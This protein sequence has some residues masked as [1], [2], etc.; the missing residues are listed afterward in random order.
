[1][2][3]SMPGLPVR[4]QLLESTQTRVHCVTNAIQPSHPLSSPS[5]P[6]LNLSQ[7]TQCLIL[8]CR[9]YH[10]SN[11]TVRD[12]FLPKNEFSLT[13][14]YLHVLYFRICLK[15]NWHS[16]YINKWQFLTHISDSYHW[17]FSSFQSLSR[18]WLCNP[19]DCSMPGFPVHH[20]LPELPQT[21]VH[22]V[23]DAI[24]PSHPLLSSFPHAL[25]VS[26]KQ[27]LFKWVSSSH[28][29]AKVLEF[30]LQHQSL[31]Q[32]PRTDLL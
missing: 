25:N 32:T 23:G 26:Q 2:N 28:Q 6:A 29:V 13:E 8:W 16:L 30:Q 15:P 18:F 9:I 24:K 20:Q 7:L 4:Q 3:C 19:M 17:Q 27:G 1:M 5:P 22:W 31:Q 12:L 21:H 14:I 11:S 10:L